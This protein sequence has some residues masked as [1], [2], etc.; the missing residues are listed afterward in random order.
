MGMGWGNAR[1]PCPVLGGPGKL[2][3]RGAQFRVGSE[4]ER[5]MPDSDASDASGYASEAIDAVDIARNLLIYIDRG[6]IDLIRALFDQIDQREN[7]GP[8]G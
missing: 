3:N 1:G 2:T 5:G 8:Q 6:E 7:L 4:Y